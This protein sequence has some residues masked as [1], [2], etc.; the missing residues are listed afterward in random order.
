MPDREE[1]ERILQAILD[2]QWD[3]VPTEDEPKGDEN[4]HD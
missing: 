4:E 1:I 3:E 2:G